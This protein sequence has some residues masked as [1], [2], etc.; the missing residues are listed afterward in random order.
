[1]DG[2]LGRVAGWIA[3]ARGDGLRVAALATGDPLCHGIASWLTGKLG[4]EGFE[5]I[6][7]V[8]TL[9]LAFARFKTAWQDVKIATGATAPTPANGWPARRRTTASTS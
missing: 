1:M 6:P 2:G 4:P 9:Q 5:I 3:D 7:A 8:S